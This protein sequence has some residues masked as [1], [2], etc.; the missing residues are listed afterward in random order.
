MIKNWL[1]IGFK[2]AVMAASGW[3][4]YTVLEHI[5]KK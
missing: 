4:A 2:L 3:I 1:D 5:G